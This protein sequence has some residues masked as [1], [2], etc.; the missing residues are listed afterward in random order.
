MVLRQH[1]VA[2][3]TADGSKLDR[4]YTSTRG[5]ESLE[6]LKKAVADIENKGMNAIQVNVIPVTKV[7]SKYSHAVMY[8]K[9]F[10]LNGNRK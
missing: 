3:S 4:P 7:G 8:G 1:V 9:P 6:N 2:Y 10:D 5:W